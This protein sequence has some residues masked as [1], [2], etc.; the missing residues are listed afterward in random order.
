[1]CETNNIKRTAGV[2]TNRGLT[3]KA[4][5]Y[6]NLIK[7]QIRNSIYN[8]NFKKMFKFLI[9]NYHSR[10]RLCFKQILTNC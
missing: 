1:M 3:H 10:Q 9:K 8:Q 7:K 4:K 5:K 6:A 2:T